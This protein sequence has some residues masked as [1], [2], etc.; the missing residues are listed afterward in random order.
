MSKLKTEAE[1]G[2][3]NYA[4]RTH[5]LLELYIYFECY[6]PYSHMCIT[7]LSSTT[8]PLAIVNVRTT[9]TPEHGAQ[10]HTG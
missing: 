9:G 5:C 7:S 1:V 10:G 2:V 6:L 3:V 8:P 4:C